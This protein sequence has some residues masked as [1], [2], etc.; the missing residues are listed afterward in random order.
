MVLFCLM[1]A[2]K[3][4]KEK[5]KK[6]EK[7][8]KMIAISWTYGVGGEWYAA[9]TRCLMK[10]RT[11]L[12]GLGVSSLDFFYCHFKLLIYEWGYVYFFL[13]ILSFFMIICFSILMENLLTIPK[14]SLEWKLI[15][16]ENEYTVSIF[17][18]N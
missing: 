4:L 1:C 17:E 16:R 13:L 8:F 11:N 5:R 6:D 15:L 9:T 14:W 2:K 3:A 7:H 10:S 12:S 18:Q